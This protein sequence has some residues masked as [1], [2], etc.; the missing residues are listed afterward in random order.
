MSDMTD[1]QDLAFNVLRFEPDEYMQIATIHKDTGEFKAY[2]APAGCITEP[3]QTLIDRQDSNLF[4]GVNP[5]VKGNGRAKANEVTRWS[6]FWLDLD[7]KDTGIQSADNAA[8]LLEAF[9]ESLNGISPNAIYSTGGG[10]QVYYMID[11]EDMPM[12]QVRLEMKRLEMHAQA[13]AERFRLGSIDS[14]A[15]PARMLRVPGSINYEYDHAPT[16]LPAFVVRA[17]AISLGSEESF[18]VFG[19]A[20]LVLPP[21][22]V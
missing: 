16:V 7:F 8:C 20:M 15:D 2:R 3:L 14:T 5:V 19:G 17:G 22:H 18:L 13:L 21:S 10:L 12:A 1:F 6:A 11:T 9:Y 4:F